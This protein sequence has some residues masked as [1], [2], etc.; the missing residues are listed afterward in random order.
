MVNGC[1]DEGCM[2]DHLIG[3]EFHMNRDNTKRLSG[4][5]S[6]LRSLENKFGEEAMKHRLGLTPGMPRFIVMKAIDG[7]DKLPS[8]TCN[9]LKW[10]WYF[11]VSHE[12]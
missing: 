6:I 8:K 2:T 11:V 12:T 10:G 4:Q 1:L 3:C 9:I 7:E 5:P